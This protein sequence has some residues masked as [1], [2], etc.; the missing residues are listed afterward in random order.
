VYATRRH[1][2]P[3]PWAEL[4]ERDGHGMTEEIP[5]GQQDRAREML[6]MGLRLMEGVSE[7]LFLARTG[8]SL[9][10]A[11]DP[12]AFQNA[13]AAGYVSWHDGRLTASHEGR[14]RLDALLPYLVV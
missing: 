9:A 4:V 5:L 1:R 11:I 7:K 12:E 13:A 10:S 2:A 14:R 8:Q 6:L 3:E